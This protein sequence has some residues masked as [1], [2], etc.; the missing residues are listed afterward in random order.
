MVESIAILPRLQVLFGRYDIMCLSLGKKGMGIIMKKLLSLALTVAM[1]LGV[2]SGCKKKI[3]KFELEV[4]DIIT[5]GKYEDE[6]IEWE[7]MHRN[8]VIGEDK[9]IVELQSTCAIECLPFN[10]DGES[11]WEDCT[12]REWL[13]NDFFEEAFTK[14]E[15]KSIIDTS[16]SMY[17]GDARWLTDKVFLPEYL[18]YRMNPQDATCEPT[19]HT[20]DLGIQ[21]ENGSCKF[22]TRDVNLMRSAGGG[23]SVGSFVMCLGTKSNNSGHGPDGLFSAEDVGVRPVISVECEGTFEMKDIDVADRVTLGTYDEDP[24]TWVVIESDKNGVN[25]LSKY[26]LEKMKMDRDEDQTDFTKTDLHDWLNEDFYEEAFTTSDKKLIVAD[27]NDDNVT[28]IEKISIKDGFDRE[29]MYELLLGCGYSR[30][31]CEENDIPDR[32]VMDTF[33]CKGVSDKNDKLMVFSIAK[34]NGGGV[35]SDEECSVRPMITIKF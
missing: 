1:I 30:A 26:A 17:T 25:L 32:D 5:M 13:N 11:S 35:N 19:D 6:D 22:W 14:S 29:C 10:E 23:T 21:M 28:L 8:F 15:K 16:Y 9:V 4:G 3:P 7:V 34:M 24:I 27:D 31:Y 12:L 33:W 18:K 2:T 20:E